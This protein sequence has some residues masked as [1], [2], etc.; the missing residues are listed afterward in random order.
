MP[1]PAALAARLAKRGIIHADEVKKGNNCTLV[2]GSC[3]GLLTL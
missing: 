2:C 3:G 1:L